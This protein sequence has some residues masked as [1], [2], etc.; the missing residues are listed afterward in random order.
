MRPGGTADVEAR[1]RSLVRQYGWNATSFQVLQPGFRY[2]FPTD[3]Q[4]SHCGKNEDAR[5]G[6][7]EGDACIAYVDTGRAWV[8]AG[9]P[10]SPPERFPVLTEA[11]VNAARA[12]GR[13]AS[14]FATEERFATTVSLSSLLIGEQ[15]VWEPGAWAD[16]LA[17]T[18]RLREQLRRAH[19]KRVLVRTA[20]AREIHNM[21]A[22]MHAQAAELVRRWAGAHELAP[23]GFLVQADPF[24]MRDDHRLYLAELD[25]RLV[26]LLAACPI[27]ARHGWLIEM[28]VRAPDA[29]NG[30]VDLLVDEAMRAAAAGED[31][32][33]TLGLAPLSGDIERPLRWARAAG[34]V[35]FDFEGLRAFKARLRPARWDR[36][37][38]SFPARQGAIRSVIDVLAAFARGRLLRFGVETLLRGPALV[39]RALA[40]ALVP[41]TVALAAMDWT[42]WFPHRAVKWAWVAFDMMLATGLLLLARRWRD[43]LAH[44]LIAAIALDTGLTLF[45]VV[46][47]NL[48]RIHVWSQFAVMAVAIFGPATALAF[49]WRARTRRR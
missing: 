16:T 1:V 15:A 2:F 28:L 17:R 40:L 9:A 6:P 46:T 27:F 20:T 38:L 12:A 22:P 13:R 37:Y 25:G 48:P 49:L 8:A 24:A 44:A 30:T 35:L 41:W 23:M 29:P 26:G 39:V 42:P 5:E 3:G 45:E 18:P 47:F 4:G 33:V 32:L 34:T 14:F 21:A 7:R 10:L 43:R 31:E 19:A 11:F 36:I